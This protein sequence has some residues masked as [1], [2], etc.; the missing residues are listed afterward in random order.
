MLE[1]TGTHKADFT[2]THN[3]KPLALDERLV[4][5]PQ[6]AKMVASRVQSDLSTGRLYAPHEDLRKQPPRSSAVEPRWTTT[7]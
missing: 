5:E 4:R 7:E 1:W 2:H 6:S 3:L